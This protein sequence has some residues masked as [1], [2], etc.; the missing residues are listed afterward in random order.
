MFLPSVSTDYL[1]VGFV[2]SFHFHLYNFLHL[3]K[4]FVVSLCQKKKHEKLSK[5]S[6]L[7]ADI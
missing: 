5:I 4:L 1:L 6:I 3:F 7:K 2:V